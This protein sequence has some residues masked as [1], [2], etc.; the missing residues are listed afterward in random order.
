LEE[1]NEDR[2][3][4]ALERVRRDKHDPWGYMLFTFLNG[5]AQGL[6]VA[7]GMT[8]ILG[9]VIYIVTSF[10]AHMVNFPVIGHYFTEI[11]KILDAYIKTAPKVR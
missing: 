8:L 7:L 5:V 1:P 11:S 6:G 4:E 9:L 2:L 10:L 3:I